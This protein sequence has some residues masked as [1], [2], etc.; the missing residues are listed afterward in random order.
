MLKNLKKAPS[1]TQ[2]ILRTVQLLKAVAERKE[3]G[4]RLTDLAAHCGLEKSTAY[5]IV[6]GL[7]SQR[8]LRQRPRDRRYVAGPL[9][10]ELS[11][12]LPTHD[13]F[14]QAVHTHL[15]DLTRRLNGIAVLYLLAGNETVCIDRVGE[16][17]PPPLTG[18]GTR[19]PLLQS[20]FGMSMLLAMPKARQKEFLQ[21]AGAKP[22]SGDRAAGYRRILQRSR[23]Y[24]FGLNIDDIVPALTTV[25]VPVFDQNGFPFA[26]IGIMAPTRDVPESR[27]ASIAKIL[28][29][30]VR[31]LETEHSELIVEL[32]QAM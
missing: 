16:T 24:G 26:S 12:A 15:L 1:G 30:R 22:S 14:K 13:A 23:R 7:A 31:R 9:L 17:S 3:I 10:Y 18:I 25:A 5:R 4:W 28:N 20:T 11:L 29:E 27:L 8:V 2:T 6:A 21:P 32:S 19:R